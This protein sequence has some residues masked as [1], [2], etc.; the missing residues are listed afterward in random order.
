[1]RVI[2]NTECIVIHIY[3]RH[4]VHSRGK[5]EEINKPYY[6][7]TVNSIFSNEIDI[8]S[9]LSDKNDG[10]QPM[11][12]ECDSQTDSFLPKPLTPRYVPRKTGIDRATQV[13]DVR[14]LFNFDLEVQPI[15]DVIVRKTIEQALFEVKSEE[16]ILSLVTIQSEY[17]KIQ[18]KEKEWIKQKITEAQEETDG[19]RSRRKKKH[20]AAATGA[21]A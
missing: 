12:T 8:S 4:K 14:E 16:D 1:V 10:L 11:R 13:E 21:A 2:T 17:H 7:Y 9:N 20:Q 19:R 3:R 6:Q 18:E 5:V 15:L